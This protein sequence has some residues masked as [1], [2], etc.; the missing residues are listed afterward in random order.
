MFGY[1]TDL[2]SSSQGRAVFTM[3][4]HHYAPVPTHIAESIATK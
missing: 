4:Y 2:R 3:E 1:S